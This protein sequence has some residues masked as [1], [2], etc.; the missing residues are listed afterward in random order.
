MWLDGQ[1]NPLQPFATLGS[2]Q[3]SPIVTNP[4]TTSIS[5]MAGQ[6]CKNSCLRKQKFLLGGTFVPPPRLAFRV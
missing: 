1:I 4:K 3:S 2:I 6:Y 5:Q